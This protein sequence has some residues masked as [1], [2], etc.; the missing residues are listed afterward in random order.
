MTDRI[1]DL[2][3][4]I[5]L[6]LSVAAL[7]ELVARAVRAEA[8]LERFTEAV[9]EASELVEQYADGKLDPLVALGKIGHKLLVLAG[10]E[11]KP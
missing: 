9:M 11:G 7:A 4:T 8:A 6:G 5:R 1:T 10:Q 2:E 3:A